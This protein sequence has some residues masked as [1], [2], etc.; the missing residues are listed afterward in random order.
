MHNHLR[1]QRLVKVIMG[2]MWTYMAELCRR[3]AV[4]W[5]CCIQ[6]S[7]LCPQKA[8]RSAHA[9]ASHPDL[10]RT[11][12]VSRCSPHSTSGTSLRLSICGQQMQRRKASAQR[13]V[14]EDD[15]GSTLIPQPFGCGCDLIRCLLEVQVSHELHQHKTS[16]AARLLPPY[17]QET[18]V[19]AEANLRLHF[20]V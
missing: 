8:Q 15:L 9:E 19:K 1:A 10:N 12:P 4:E 13:G 17:R 7:I 14:S 2:A 18:L 5:G 6:A 16:A 20:L 3:C 11:S